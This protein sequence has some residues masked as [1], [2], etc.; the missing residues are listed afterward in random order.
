MKYY[1]KESISHEE[2]KSLP[3]G[4]TYFK[5]EL[6]DEM[7]LETHEVVGRYTTLR[8]ARSACRSY[9]REELDGG[10]TFNIL[11]FVINE[12]GHPRVIGEAIF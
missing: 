7:G 12:D 1:V 2:A 3:I 8:K 10:G 6:L 4:V 11:C 5:V 9:A